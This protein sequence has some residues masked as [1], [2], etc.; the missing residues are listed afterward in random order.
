MVHFTYGDTLVLLQSFLDVMSTDSVPISELGYFG[1]HK[2][3]V[4]RDQ[5]SAKARFNE[6]KLILGELLSDFWMLARGP[7]HTSWDDGL[8]RGFR[9]MFDTRKVPI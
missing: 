4:D 9:T 6:D 3:R 5:M 1:V 8:T 7:G 2:P